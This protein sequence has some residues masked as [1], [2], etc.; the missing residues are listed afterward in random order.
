MDIGKCVADFVLRIVL[1]LVAGPS[2][3]QPVVGRHNSGRNRIHLLVVLRVGFLVE[4]ELVEAVDQRIRRRHIGFCGNVKPR[5]GVEVVVLRLAGGMGLVVVFRLAARPTVVVRV[6]VEDDLRPRS[7]VREVHSVIPVVPAG[8]IRMTIGVLDSLDVG[9]DICVG[10]PIGPQRHGIDRTLDPKAHAI[11]GVES[12]FAGPG[13]VLAGEPPR[14]VRIVGVELGVETSLGDLKADALPG[15]R[16]GRVQAD[17]GGPV[18]LVLAGISRSGLV[19]WQ[20]G[21]IEGQQRHRRLLCRTA[22]MG[23]PRSTDQND[24]P[25]DEGQFHGTIPCGRVTLPDSP[26]PLHRGSGLRRIA[27]AVEHLRQ[28]G[29]YGRRPDL[30]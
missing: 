1:V 19:P 27:P 25:C 18:R 12:P 7:R 9:A 24:K 26:W 13:R 22:R 5:E 17:T 4:V 15:N 3:N 16:V 14:A 2:E 6:H 8:L 21:A 28:P 11:E 23:K 20:I 10:P 29:D 30:R